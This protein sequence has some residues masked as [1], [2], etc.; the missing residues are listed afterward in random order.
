MSFATRKKKPTGK[1]VAQDL[2]EETQTFREQSEPLL[3]TEITP[4]RETTDPRPE[5]EDST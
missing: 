2:E 1:A 4:L 3:T 5:I